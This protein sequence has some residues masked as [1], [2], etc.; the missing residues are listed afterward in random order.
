MMALLLLSGRQLRH[1]VITEEIMKNRKSRF[2]VVAIIVMMIFLQFVYAQTQKAYQIPFGSSNSTIELSI[3]NGSSTKQ[4]SSL[5]VIAVDVPEWIHVTPKEQSVNG[6]QSNGETITKFTFDVDKS[7]PLNKDVVLRFEI[8]SQSGETWEKEITLN[9]SKPE[10]LDLLQNYP[11]PFNPSTTISYIL[12]AT[13]HIHLKIY[14]I[15]GQI[16]ATL[17]DGEQAPGYYS[18][19]WNA[20]NFPSGIYFYQLSYAGDDGTTTTEKKVMMLLK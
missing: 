4:I 18:Q 9:I 17:V 3:V 12:P 16:V 13:A 1:I 5:K 7:A 14:N 8:S 2:L 11:N 6:L 19:T 15:L 10:K 20:G